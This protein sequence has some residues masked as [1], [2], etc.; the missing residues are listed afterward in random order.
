MKCD[1]CVI[2]Q[3]GYKTKA[4]QTTLVLANA[5]M[6]FVFKLVIHWRWL[7]SF[8]LVYYIAMNVSHVNVSRVTHTRV[9]ASR[10]NAS[11]VSPIR[12]V[13][14]LCTNVSR[15]TP[16]NLNTSHVNVSRVTYTRVNTSCDNVSRVIVLQYLRWACQFVY[17]QPFP[18]SRA[19]PTADTLMA[20]RRQV[21]QRLPRQTLRAKQHEAEGASPGI[22]YNMIFSD[23]DALKRTC[24][25]SY[26]ELLS[27]N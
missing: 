9:N 16:T 4:V 11:R 3:I 26:P 12:H 14:V 10:V 1:T 2:T 8:I 20:C 5:G 27:E 15:I 25:F 23:A 7:K 17:K 18:T 22:A 19:Q 13:N 21:Y 24:L 6:T